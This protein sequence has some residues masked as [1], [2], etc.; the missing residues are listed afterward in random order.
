MCPRKWKVSKFQVLRYRERTRNRWRTTKVVLNLFSF[1]KTDRA[2]QPRMHD[3]GLVTGVTITFKR[4]NFIWGF[5]YFKR[6]SQE[7][8]QNVVS[9]RKKIVFWKTKSGISINPNISIVK[10]YHMCGPS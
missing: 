8:S 7:S 3:D 2:P 6:Q 1:V 4:A 9:E 5:T 10:L